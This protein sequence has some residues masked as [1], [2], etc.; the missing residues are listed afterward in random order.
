VDQNL[1]TPALAP[2]ALALREVVDADRIIQDR[3]GPVDRGRAGSARRQAD[4][5]RFDEGAQDR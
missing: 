3:R 2:R 1:Y 4:E 5:L